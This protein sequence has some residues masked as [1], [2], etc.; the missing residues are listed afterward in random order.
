MFA[1]R[2]DLGGWVGAGW[3]KK[4]KSKDS[5]IMDFQ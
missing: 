5:G 2:Q 4:K 3:V 1:E